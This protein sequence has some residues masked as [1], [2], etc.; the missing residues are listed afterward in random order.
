MS[1]TFTQA[2]LDSAF[3][4]GRTAAKRKLGR[5]A[6]PYPAE[7]KRSDEWDSGYNEEESAK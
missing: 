7:D 3:L 6:N 5:R 1:R 2:E 4:T